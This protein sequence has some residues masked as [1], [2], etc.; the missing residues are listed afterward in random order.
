MDDAVKSLGSIQLETITADMM[1]NAAD[2][3]A[4]NELRTMYLDKTRQKDDCSTF[5]WGNY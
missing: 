3:G 4:Q 2:T 5:R 1:F